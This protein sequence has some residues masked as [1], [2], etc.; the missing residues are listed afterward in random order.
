MSTA[1]N[2][3]STDPNPRSAFPNPRSTN[4]WL[5]DFLKAMASDQLNIY[6]E[7]LNY[8]FLESYK[9]S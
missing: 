8:Y 1:L 3:K 5:N 2:P 9:G 4:D 6:Y 7:L